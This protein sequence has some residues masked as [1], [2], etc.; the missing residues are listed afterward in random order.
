MSR[1]VATV[2]SPGVCLN[3]VSPSTMNGEAARKST[4]A[5]PSATSVTETTAEI[6]SQASSSS[7]V[8]RRATKTGMNVAERIPPRTRSWT[9]LGIVFD[10]LKASAG[11]ALL[12][13]VPRAY[14]SA[15][16]RPTPVTRD[17]SVPTAIVVVARRRVMTGCIDVVLTPEAESALPV[18]RLCACPARRH[19]S[20]QVMVVRAVGSTSG[21]A[22]TRAPT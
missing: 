22:S 1:Y 3:T 10:R 17:R 14:P 6:A 19:R 9:M 2:R 18:S 16:I 21:H 11:D 12:I 13:P 15:T 7:R 20:R 5:A 4:D 8:A